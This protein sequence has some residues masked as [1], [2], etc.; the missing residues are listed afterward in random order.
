MADT[1]SQRPDACE[2]CGK[3][4]ESEEITYTFESDGDNTNE[5]V[6]ATFQL[7]PTPGCSQ[8]TED[9]WEMR[10]WELQTDPV[11]DDSPE[12]REQEKQRI[13]ED[14]EQLI[15]EY[16]YIRN[17]Y[18]T[19]K[20]DRSDLSSSDAEWSDPPSNLGTEDEQH[21]ADAERAATQV[22]QIVATLNGEDNE[23]TAEFR[24][25]ADTLDHDSEEYISI[26]AARQLCEFA[27]HHP[28]IVAPHAGTL[29][30]HLDSDNEILRRRIAFTVMR[31]ATEPKPFVE[32]APTFISFLDADNSVVRG[33]AAFVVGEIATVAPDD[34]VPAVG[35][36]I[37]LVD[38]PSAR[39]DAMDALAR[40]S[41]ERPQAIMAAVKSVSQNFQSLPPATNDSDPDDTVFRV[42]ALEIIANVTLV[43]PD[44]INDVS[45]AL[46]RAAQS[47]LVAVRVQA[48]D[49]IGV[50]ITERPET[51]A[52]LEAHLLAG[53]ND[54]EPRVR[55][56]TVLAYLWIAF[57]APAVVED[58]GAVA[59]RLRA[60]NETFDIPDDD[61]KDAIQAFEGTERGDDL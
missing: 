34:V 21:F 5:Q 9:R 47:V 42:A 2:E 39:A 32:Y 17:K 15:E 30:E 12:V 41:D 50:L 10:L 1:P 23:R 60:V 51:F 53:F 4:K 11:L 43:D 59:N 52:S 48:A 33:T 20:E 6:A 26:M 56:A 35:S 61:L 7:C 57:T 24:H 40:I 16:K 8:W 13:E 29:V 44:T 18:V 3:W 28:D 19:R 49:T 58:P 36:L 37:P 22:P 45:D 54:E 14:R 25:K 31:A 55:R 46:D 38:D 27:S